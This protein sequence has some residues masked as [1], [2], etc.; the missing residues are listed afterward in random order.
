MF[1]QLDVTA[2]SMARDVV[3]N[4]TEQVILHPQ[5]FNSGGKTFACHGGQL[6]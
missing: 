2:P 1:T 6:P 5:M 4:S 3:G